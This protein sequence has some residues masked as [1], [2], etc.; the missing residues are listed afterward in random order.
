[1]KFSNGKK[2]TVMSIIFLV[3]AVVT[4]FTDSSEIVTVGALLLS[5]LEQ[6]D[7]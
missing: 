6:A 1:M 4:L 5:S 2:Q 3:L 7:E